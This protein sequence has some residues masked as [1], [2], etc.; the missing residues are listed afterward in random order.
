MVLVLFSC[1]MERMHGVNSFSSS[2]ARTYAQTHT[3][4]FRPSLCHIYTT[5]LISSL[6]IKNIHCLHTTLPE[7]IRISSVSV[8][9]SKSTSC[10]LGNN[11]FFLSVSLCWLAAQFCLHNKTICRKCF[12]I[13][14]RVV[15]FF[16]PTQ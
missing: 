15:F 11:F 12:Y 6:T 13:I 2:Y 9:L 10:S 8:V 4:L 7:R 14:S 3:H 5:L 1:N 16:S